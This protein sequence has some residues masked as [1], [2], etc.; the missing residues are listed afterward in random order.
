MNECSCRNAEM[1]KCRDAEMHRC[2][3]R[4]ASY[5]LAA[6]MQ[7]HYSCNCRNAAAEMQ[8]CSCS[9]RNVEMQLQKFKKNVAAG[10]YKYSCRNPEMQ[11]HKL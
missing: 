11:L 3:C 8:E 4:N 6:E 10:M 9:Y 5:N 2:N 1:Q 7:L